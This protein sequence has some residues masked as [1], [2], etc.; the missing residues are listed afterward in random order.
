MLLARVQA[1]AREKLMGKCIFSMGVREV[2]Q[3]IV[4]GVAVNPD[5]QHIWEPLASTPAT[6]VYFGRDTAPFRSWAEERREKRTH[7]WRTVERYF[8]EALGALRSRE[9]DLRGNR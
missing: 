4:I 5:D 6:L 2:D 8:E 7:P 1:S 9:F 3:I